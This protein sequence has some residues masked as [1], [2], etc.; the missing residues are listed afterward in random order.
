MNQFSARHAAAALATCVALAGVHSTSFAA[1]ADEPAIDMHYGA[2]IEAYTKDMAAAK[3]K[4]DGKRL[5]FVGAVIRMG[6][7]P[8]GTYFGAVTTDGAQFDTHFDV[9]DQDALKPKFPGREI[10]AFTA[11]GNLRFSCLNEGY[12]DAPVL[13]GL[14]LTHCRLAE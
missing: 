2:V 3:A 1:P 10:K 12:I 11:S 9:A 14:K 7:D 6:S 4:Y 13:P 5:T 8:G